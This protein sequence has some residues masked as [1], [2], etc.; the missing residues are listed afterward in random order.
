NFHPPHFTKLPLN[1]VPRPSNRLSSAGEG[2][3]TVSPK[4]SQGVFYRKMNFS[5]QRLFS[6][7]IALF[8]NNSCLRP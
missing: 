4:E 8:S 2:V 7:Q 1:S 3:F 6:L 5:S